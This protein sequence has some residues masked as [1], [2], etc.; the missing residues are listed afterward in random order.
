[1]KQYHQYRMYFNA[2]SLDFSA[3]CMGLS[4]FLSVMYHLAFR[5]LDAFST[6]TLIIQL[7]LPLFFGMLYLVL[8]RGIRWNAPGLYAIIGAVFCV[9]YILDAF[10]S[11]SVGKILLGV[12]SWLICAAALVIVVGGYFPSRLPASL[13]FGLAIGLRVVLFDIGRLNAL[14]WVAEAAHL[15]SMAAFLFLP[16]GLKERKRRKELS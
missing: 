8:L 12:P 3:L 1:M 4:M 6:G 15:F 13:L 10:T 7:W 9:I 2:K 16:V 11:G 14:E 5:G